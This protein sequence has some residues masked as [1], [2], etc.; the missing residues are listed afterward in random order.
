MFAAVF[1]LPLALAKNSYTFDFGLETT[2]VFVASIVA[3]AVFFGVVVAAVVV[4]AI[5]SL[6]SLDG[7]QRIAMERKAAENS[8]AFVWMSQH[9]VGRIF[10]IVI[11][12]TRIVNAR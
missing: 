1:V 9:F 6:R 7:Q 11:R 10:D 5:G 2:D 4:V 3:G 12:S 8:V